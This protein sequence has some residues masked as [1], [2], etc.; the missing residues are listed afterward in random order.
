MNANRLFVYDTVKEACL[1]YVTHFRLILI[2]AVI[3]SIPEVL[4]VLIIQI[5]GEAWWAQVTGKA[6]LG[7]ATFIMDAMKNAALFAAL[8]NGGPSQWSLL[9][10][11]I[12][13]FAARLVGVHVSIA[14]IGMIVI[15][16]VSFSVAF[17]GIYES[18]TFVTIFSVA[19]AILWVIFLKYALADPLVVIENR[20]AWDALRQSWYMTRNHVSYVAANYIVLGVPLALIGIA[21]GRYLPGGWLGV[22]AD[23]L[24][25]L[26]LHILQAFWVTLAWAMY[27][28]IKIADE[29]SGTFSGPPSPTYPVNEFTP[30]LPPSDPKV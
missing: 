26:P 11:S 6:L 1:L 19:M 15:A 4:Q 5:G 12:N 8:A 23:D 30:I 10:D 3:L 14:V 18:S 13:R 25:R 16:P 9:R 27:R 29:N 20:Y 22:L 2:I 24:Y 28:R 17:F 7:V 21:V